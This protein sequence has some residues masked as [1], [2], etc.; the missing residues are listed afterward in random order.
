[1]DFTSKSKVLLLIF[2]THYS[3]YRAVMGALPNLRSI[4]EAMVVASHIFEMIDRLPTIDLD[5]QTGL[6]L[7]HVRGEIEFKIVDFAYPSRPDSPVLQGFDLK[8][9]AGMT[10]G[11]VGSS[12]SGKSTV[13]SLLERFY[14]PSRGEILF[15]QMNI[16]RLQLRWLR[17]QMGLVS[18]EPILFATS[19]KENMLFGNDAATMELVVRAARVA[20]AHDFITKLPD[21][22]ETQVGQ[23]GVQM[24]GG[25][26]QR[27]S[28]ARALL[29][30]PR[31]LLLDEATSALDAESESAVQDALDL[32][33][34]GRTTIIITHRLSTIHN[35]DLIAVLQSGKVVESGSHHQLNQVSNGAYSAM[36]QS[37]QSIMKNEDS[38]TN[39]PEKEGSNNHKMLNSKNSSIIGLSNCSPSPS[40][41]QASSPSPSSVIQG[42]HPNSPKE[43]SSMKS[44]MGSPS[45][46]RMM[47]MNSPEWKR[48]MLGCLGAIGFGAVQPLHSYCMGSV[49]GVYLKNDKG[50]IRSEIRLYCFFFLAIAFVSIVSNLIQHYNFA[51]MGERL[52]KRIREKMLRRMLTFEIGWFDRDENL[53]AVIVARLATEANVVR[54]LIGDRLSL[55]IQVTSTASLAF[56]MGLVIAWKVA[57]VMIAMQ[58]LI[59][60]C[61][62]SKRVLMANMSAKA[63]KAQNEGSQLASEAVVNYRTIAAFSSQ[64]RVLDLYEIA[65]KG[66][67]RETMKH[68]WFVGLG[69]SISQFVTTASIAIT[70]WYGGRLVL[71]GEIIPKHLL[72]VFFTLMGTGKVIADAGSMTSDLAKGSGAVQSVFEILD[73]RS[74]IEP[75]D[76]KGIKPRKMIKGHVELKNVFFSYPSRPGQMI[77]RGLCLKIE[78]GKT[79]AL[80]G[81]SGSGKSTLISLIERFYDP[82][83]GSVEIDGQDIRSFNL[84]HLRSNI[85][86]VSQEPVLFAG[87]IREN[88][89]YGNENV[90]ETEIAEAANL[91]N[92]HEF[93]SSMQD[94]Y[95]TYCG[96]RGVQISGGQKQRIVIARAMLRNPAIL[97]LDEATSALDAASESLVQEALEKMI[98]GRR[99]CVIVAHRLSMIQK[100]ESISVIKDGKIVEEGSHSHL[101]AIGDGGS[102]YS[103][104]KLQNQNKIIIE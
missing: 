100:L 54:S 80:V 29:K 25:Q 74:E 1:M 47:K 83:K 76:P 9:I 67:K 3:P 27:I 75:D 11:L 66:P 35:A 8:V 56:I 82:L 89:A 52:T 55:L 40:S 57:I 32:A 98:T 30:D 48:A 39:S 5:D 21:G 72:Q 12:G 16:K 49:A 41:I 22:Y 50:L 62:Y 88:I 93:I 28:I 65:S 14:D 4:S 84:R 17:S 73:R 92:A 45:Q 86:L 15:D 33:S 87:T 34:V 78:A 53:S 2:G 90:T 18:Q 68:S 64:K 77:F 19:I 10:I 24:S 38:T 6:T 7:E 99:T 36:L 70:F 44:S 69:L 43:G 37:Q 71:Q 61:F 60:S 91:A 26:K 59:I 31:I 81:Q 58:P 95:E 101:M 13:I 102:Y 46:W 20:N 23:F 51:I 103:L 79:I 97:L 85:A 104:M 42:H 96:E 63:R 94:G